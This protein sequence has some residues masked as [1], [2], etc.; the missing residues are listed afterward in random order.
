MRRKE[1]PRFPRVKPG[2]DGR[3]RSVDVLG[4]PQDADVPA[5]K[6]AFRRLAKVL[7]PDR[8]PHPRAGVRFRELVWA[9]E[10][11]LQNPFH[12]DHAPASD[13]PHATSA[14]DFDPFDFA[15]EVREVGE[16]DLDG[17]APSA[18]CTVAYQVRLARVVVSSLIGSVA[19]FCA[20][21]VLSHF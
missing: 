16:I 8:N 9:Y 19:A 4:L 18:F 10:A 21:S 17:A 2:S 14:V 3:R 6:N 12:D 13:G 5:I 1:K 7:H 20:S 15:R 11:M